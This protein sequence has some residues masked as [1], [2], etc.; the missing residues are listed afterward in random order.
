MIHI[1]NTQA[2]E[3]LEPTSQWVA[4]ENPE[5]YPTGL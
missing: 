2:L 4:G 3:P 5:T 1:E